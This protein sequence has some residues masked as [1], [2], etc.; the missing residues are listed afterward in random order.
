V[1]TGTDTRPTPSTSTTN[2]VG[3]NG[4][5]GAHGDRIDILRAQE[6]TA[7]SSAPCNSAAHRPPFVTPFAAGRVRCR[8]ASSGDDGSGPTTLA[9]VTSDARRGPPVQ[10]LRFLLEGP[11]KIGK[12]T[13]M[14]R[15]VELLRD[16]GVVV[17]GFV[18]DE[19]REQDRRVGF[20]IHDL[21]GPEV[22]LA[23]QDL[24]TSVRVGRFG[25]DVPAF[26]RVAL[27]ALRR[28]QETGG[29]VII[30]EIG[31]MELASAPFVEAVDAVL[32]GSLPVVATVHVYEHPVTDALKRRS[33]GQHV[34]VTEANRDELPA[35]LF[36]QLM[37]SV[38]LI[39]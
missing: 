6:P 26:E 17:S 23:H 31:R 25:V 9:R 29:V 34:T 7:A 3:R 28:A 10:P 13:T 20:V 35:Q 27:P 24:Q 4:G 22:V 33:D 5:L 14:R 2:R 12:T 37:Q 16:H 1:A 32:A 8:R 21:A 18:T 19:V 11:P 15:L 36:R 39:G 38:G 30:D